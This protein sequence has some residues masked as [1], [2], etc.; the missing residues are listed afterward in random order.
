MSIWRELLSHER[1][2]WREGVRNDPSFWTGTSK[3]GI[4]TTAHYCAT[5]AGVEVLEAGGNAVDASVA[6]SLALGVAE[7]AGSGLGGMAMMMIHRA[8]GNRTFALEGPCRAPLRATP[9]EAAQASRRLGYKAI[10]VPTNPAVLDYALNKYGT[11]SIDKLIEPAVKLAEEGY[12]ITPLRY[13]ITQEYLA[14]LAKTNAAYFMLSPD[15]K[16]FPPGTIF[17]QPALARTLRRLGQAGLQDFY[18]GE[19]GKRIIE[20]ITLNG[21]FITAEDFTSIP[22]PGEKE[23]LTAPFGDWTVHTLAPPGGGTT[24]IQMLNLFSELAYNDFNPDTPEAAVLFSALIRRAR[25]DRRKYRP[26]RPEFV[27]KDA[28]DLANPLYA[29]AIAEE[30]RPDFTGSGETSHLCVMDQYGNVVSLTQS[31]ERS[32]GAKV[33]T[34]DLGFLYNGFMKG[35]KV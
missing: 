5:G 32:F 3:A 23:P 15:K 30:L 21:G 25:L 29:K 13:R 1:M 27:Q 33:V 34:K 6:A 16:P 18:T 10:A 22:Y 28:P 19:I 8:S 12:P 26:C 4:V 9:E 20:D 14:S 35:F 2:V 31:I 7:P 11:M 17:R 24:L